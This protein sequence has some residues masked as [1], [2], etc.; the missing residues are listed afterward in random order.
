MPNDTLRLIC[1]ACGKT[2]DV[3]AELERFSCLY[4]GAKHRMAELLPP[5]QPA[6][7]ADRAFAEAHLLDCVRDFPNY[8]KQF[9]RKK[10]EAAYRKHLEALRPCYEAMDRWVCAQPRMRRELLE[11]FADSFLDQWESWHKGL[12]RR[13][14]AR[15]RLEFANK[16][17][18]AFFTAP[19]IR[20]LGLSVSEDYP[21]LLAERFT[22]RYPD[23]AFLAGSYEEISTGFR[24]R[25]L[26]GLFSK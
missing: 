3:P 24:K 17:T 9:T 14:H 13:K 23:N 19:A 18:L 25:G 11:A 21:Q 1:P 5:T 7:E 4:C 2:I 6:D 20:G 16:L 10:Y 12:T 22:A 26:A 15:G 8:Y